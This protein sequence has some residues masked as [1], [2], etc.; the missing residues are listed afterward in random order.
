MDHPLFSTIPYLNTCEPNWSNLSSQP[1]KIASIEVLRIKRRRIGLPF[2]FPRN[3]EELYLIRTRSTDGAMG[4][5]VAHERI[6]HFYPILQ[7][8]VIPYFIGKDIRNIVSLIDEVYVFRSNYKLSGLALWCCVAW[9]EISLLDLLGK[10][11]NKS[12][13]ELF[14]K[15]VQ[16]QI[17][18]YLSSLRR[19]TTPEEEVDWV[20][21]RLA[22]TGATAVKFKIGGRMSHDADAMPKRTE[23]LVALARNT[24]GD[25]V[26]IGVDGNGSYSAQKAVEIGKMLEDY[27]I[28]FFEEPCPF[29]EFDLTEKVAHSLALPIAGGEQ[30]T[31]LARFKQMIHRQ[32]VDILQPDLIYNGGFIRTFRVVQVAAQAK[33]PVTL[34]NARLGI[35]PIYMLHFASCLPRNHQEYNARMEKIPSWFTP[36]LIP[37]NGLLRVPR[38]P[39][40]GIEID[41]GILRK[42]RKLAIQAI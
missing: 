13:G 12:V 6:K 35:D 4:I 28:S 14:G 5:S 22:E 27:G 25:S 15:V 38:G 34:H 31:S 11:F 42:A 3:N 26:S 16:D 32:I 18:I 23:Q 9:V 8:L 19:D 30:E 7:Q 24:L 1:I 21:Q 37:K 39:G 10:V 17:P 20:G 40:L 29:D 41:P 33:M 36:S 2:I